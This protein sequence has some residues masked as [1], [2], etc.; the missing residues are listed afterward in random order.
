MTGNKIYVDLEICCDPKLTIVEAHT[1]AEN[2]HDNIETNFP[3]VKHVMV[4]VNPYEDV[5][6]LQ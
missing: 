3:D 5:D 4:H 2:V 1:I 6:N